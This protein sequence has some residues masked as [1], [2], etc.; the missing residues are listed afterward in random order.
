MKIN[1]IKVDG[2]RCLCNI[3][4]DFEDTITL[5]VGENDAGKS[6]LIDCLGLFTGEYAIEE[7]DFNHDKD[8]ITVEMYTDDFTFTKVHKK[9]ESPTGS[10]TAKPSA[11]YVGEVAEFVQSLDGDLT[12]EADRLKDYC[13]QFGV[14]VRANSNID[15]LKSKLTTI[16][17]EEDI[18][19]QDYA[20]PTVS[21]I[22]LDGKK[23]EDVESFFKEVFIKDKQLE[24]WDTPVIDSQT[25]KEFVQQELNNYSD[26]IASD[27]ESKGIKEKLQQYLRHLTDIKIEP[28]FEPRSLNISPRV[29]FLENGNEISV[30]KKG[31]GT[32]RRITLALLE[33]KVGEEDGD[34]SKL[35]VLDEPDTHLHVKAQLELY[36]VLKDLSDKG[37]QII[38]TTHSPFLINSVKPR[39]IRLLHQYDVNLT[40]LRSLKSEPETSDVILRQLGIE[41][42]Y[43]Y[44]AKK[45]ILVEGETEEAFLPRVYERLH[46]ITLSADLIKIIN[47]RGIK[48]IPGFSK[49][50]LELVDKQSI[51]ILTDNDMSEEVEKLI[52]ELEIPQERQTSIGTKEFE[53]SFEDEVLFNAWKDYIEASGKTIE[54]SNWTIEFITQLRQDCDTGSEKKFSSGLK[55][56]TARCGKKFTKL[57]FGEILGNHCD[58]TNTPQIIKTLLTQLKGDV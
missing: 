57:T 21:K 39:Q 38:L 27:L 52:E 34:G 16:L 40:Q 3:E 47:V 28:S 55:S 25:I 6:S 46:G 4:I 23:F 54:N 5:I 11:M 42:I 58:E 1:K 45:I 22:Q 33:Y 31:D 37:C 17:S 41:N 32:K 53:D 49:A 50:L 20:I 13:R 15:T 56:L 18:T 44:F 29:K 7:D 51:H 35:Y 24:I 19:L 10:T 12:D 2:F 48:N 36:S 43:L 26:Q 9:D 14:P 8:V 30:E